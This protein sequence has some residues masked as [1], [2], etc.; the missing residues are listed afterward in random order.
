LVDWDTIQLVDVLDDEGRL[1]VASEEQIY[2]ILGLQKEDESEK[3]E[4]E[5]GG[6][7]CSVQNE[8]D[9]SAPAIPIFQQ[10]L[11]ER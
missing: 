9:D 1:E 4:M 11:G 10:L 2:A 6:A 8:C 3:K 7:G 5:G